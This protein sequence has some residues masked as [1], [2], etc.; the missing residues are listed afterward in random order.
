MPP[1]THVQEFNSIIMWFLKVLKQKN[2]ASNSVALFCTRI[3]TAKNTLETCL[4]ENCGP[5]LFKYRENID[6]PPDPNSSDDML[7]AFAEDTKLINKHTDEWEILN[8]IGQQYSKSTPD[9][10]RV[11]HEKLRKLLDK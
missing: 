1:P 11:F 7:P 9:E 5:F 10:K 8:L 6:N 2:P 4:I 3:S